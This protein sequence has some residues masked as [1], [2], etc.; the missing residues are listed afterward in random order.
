MLVDDTNRELMLE[1]AF[2]VCLTA[3]LDALER[4]LS[5]GEGRP[6]AGNW[7]ELLLR[8]QTAYDHLP[9]HIDTTGK[10]PDTVAHEIIALW[11]ESR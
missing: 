9:H 5:G 2:V 1:S 11:N 4:R 7:Q 8:R 3:S 6:L 10:S